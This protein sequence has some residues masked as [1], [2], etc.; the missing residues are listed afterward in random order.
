MMGCTGKK[1]IRIALAGAALAFGMCTSIPTL[2]A[3]E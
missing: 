1:T 2:R 3:Q